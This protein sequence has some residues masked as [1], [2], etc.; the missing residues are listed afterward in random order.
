MGGEGFFKVGGGGGK[1]FFK[2]GGGE[3]KP[4]LR[5]DFAD[6]RP[7]LHRQPITFRLLNTNAKG[8]PV[9]HGLFLAFI[10]GSFLF[11]WVF[12]SK[13]CRGEGGKGFFKVKGGGQALF[14]APGKIKYP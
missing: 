10:F 12:R 1:G 9:I 3:C 4:F 8:C 13:T 2:V 5:Y 6:V 7:F 14:E 11:F